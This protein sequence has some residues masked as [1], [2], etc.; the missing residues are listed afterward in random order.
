MEQN[1][2]P[3][4]DAQAERGTP[5]PAFV[6][7]L[8]ANDKWLPKRMLH[9]A[10]AIS[11][12][13]LIVRERLQHECEGTLIKMTTEPVPEDVVD[14]ERHHRELAATTNLYFVYQVLD[15]R[16]RHMDVVRQRGY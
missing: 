13:D 8:F 3:T 16:D 9:I 10:E 4:P 15:R 11:Q 2:N 5:S 14:R 12:L 1:T 7:T 6:D